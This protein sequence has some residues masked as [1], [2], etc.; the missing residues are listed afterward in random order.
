[1]RIEHLLLTVLALV[2]WGLILV[3]VHFANAQEREI[4]VPYA[5][6]TEFDTT[7]PKVAVQR[8]AWPW[9]ACSEP[10]VTVELRNRIQ[11]DAAAPGEPTIRSVTWLYTDPAG[12][13]TAVIRHE[14]TWVLYGPYGSLDD[15]LK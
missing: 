4:Q 2:I 6:E 5:A 12:N 11:R 10:G 15:L 3:S 1:M 13:Q 9:P 7:P 8:A 14:R